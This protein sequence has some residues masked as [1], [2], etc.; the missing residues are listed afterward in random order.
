MSLEVLGA[1][2]FGVGESGPRFFDLGLATLQVAPRSVSERRLGNEGFETG[3]CNR[4]TPATLDDG[5]VHMIAL[6]THDTSS[7][8][9]VWNPRFRSIGHGVFREHQPHA[10][11]VNSVVTA[12]RI[13]CEDSA[14]PVSVRT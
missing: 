6:C 11:C 10:S 7:Y 14:R 5:F 8:T 3:L 2:A 13:V 9:V 12:E 4:R 1:L